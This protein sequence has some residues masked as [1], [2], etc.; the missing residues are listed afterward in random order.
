MDAELTPEQCLVVRRRKS[1]RERI[2][3]NALLG[4]CTLCGKKKPRRSGYRRCA[5]CRKKMAEFSSKY[6]QEYV[7]SGLCYRCGKVKADSLCT[8]C[9]KYKKDLRTEL[10]ELGV[11]TKCEQKPRE[12]G[13][14]RCVECRQKD[15]DYQ[16][17]RYQPREVKCG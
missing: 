2:F 10:Y 5:D 6:R 14:T 9:C 1:Q 11:C 15:R 8:D 13:Y 7:A 17:K 4:K 3:K 12:E 16:R